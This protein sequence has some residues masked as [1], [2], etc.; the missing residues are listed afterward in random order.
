M[1]ISDWSSDVCS[2]D[3]ESARVFTLKINDDGTYTFTL[4]KPIDAI[5][6]VSIGAATSFGSGP[7]GY[8]VLSETSESEGLAIISSS[9]GIN[10][11]TSGWGVD[12]HNFDTGELIRVDFGAK[13]GNL[14]RKSTSLNSSH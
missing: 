12:N 3:L 10:G 6:T 8:Q 11:S 13:E 9:G 7:T 4:L 1:R 5:E 14:D 2:S